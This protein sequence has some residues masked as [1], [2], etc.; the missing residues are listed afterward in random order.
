VFLPNQTCPLLDKDTKQCTDYEH[1]FNKV[2]YCLHGKS[3]FR[4]GGLPKG[5]LYLIGHPEREPNPKV[6]IR[7]VIGKISCEEL[8]QFMFLNNYTKFLQEIV[9]KNKK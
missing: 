9:L 3:M 8:T 6:D 2:P 5:C 4:K 7:E 1:R